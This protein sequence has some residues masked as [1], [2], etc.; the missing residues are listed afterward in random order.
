MTFV[1]AEMGIVISDTYET[2]HSKHCTKY[3]VVHRV[4]KME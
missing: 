3:R 2:N 4:W 1:R